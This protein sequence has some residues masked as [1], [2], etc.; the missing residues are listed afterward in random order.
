[1]FCLLIF[2]KHKKKSYNLPIN[3]T[4][5][6]KNSGV[7]AR[8]GIEHLLFFSSSKWHNFRRSLNIFK[9]L[10]FFFLSNR[11]RLINYW[12]VSK[13]K[14]KMKKKTIFR[15]VNIT[16]IV[17]R[18]CRATISESFRVRPNR[19]QRQTRRRVRYRWRTQGTRDK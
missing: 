8:L 9:M 6:E 16:I 15:Y 5:H 18:V 17:N 13:K 2:V 10:I 19:R 14:K 4:V 11:M 3:F 12:N 7:R 1:M